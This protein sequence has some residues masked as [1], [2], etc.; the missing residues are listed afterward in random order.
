M[1]FPIAIIFPSA[2][3]RSVSS[4]SLP[5]PSRI[6]PLIKSIFSDWSGSY[7]DS[8]AAKVS[9]LIVRE[10]KTKKSFFIFLY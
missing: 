8:K 1:P 7:V 2:I 4:N 10:N 9:T 3:R 5:S 6:F